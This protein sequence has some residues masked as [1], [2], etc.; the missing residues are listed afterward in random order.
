MNKN[1]CPS[2]FWAD[3]KYHLFKLAFWIILDWFSWNG[4]NG[5]IENCIIESTV[6]NWRNKSKLPLFTRVGLSMWRNV[7]R[8]V[9]IRRLGH[10][11]TWEGGDCGLN[12]A[13][14]SDLAIGR[15]C[16]VE[17]VHVHC[18]ISRLTT[19]T[20][21]TSYYG[22]FKHTHHFHEWCVKDVVW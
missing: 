4:S 1:Y 12:W 3:W 17:L 13:K 19:S 5:V 16:W 2:L 22:S 21:K 20:G 9:A 10:S 15:Y 6:K 11:W 7:P 14:A 18:I 8:I